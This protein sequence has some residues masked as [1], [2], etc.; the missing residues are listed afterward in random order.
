MQ[1]ELNGTTAGV[2]YDRINLS[3]TVN[4]GSSA[5]AAT[6]GY[7]P[8][9]NDTYTIVANATSVAGKFGNLLKVGGVSYLVTPA[10]YFSVA[11]GSNSVTLQY[12]GTKEPKAPG[13]IINI[14]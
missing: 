7:T 6:V 2:T 10:G 4:L 12:T 11:Y 9:V 13:T 14:R 3:G 1:V 8:Q 5:L